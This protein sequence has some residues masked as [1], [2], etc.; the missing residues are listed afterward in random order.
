LPT[1][2]SATLASLGNHNGNTPTAARPALTS[3]NARSA[4]F[5]GYAENP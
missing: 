2:L 3:K 5:L 1:D 4:L